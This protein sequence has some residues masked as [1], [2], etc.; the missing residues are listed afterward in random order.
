[1]KEMMFH[2]VLWMSTTKFAK[3]AAALYVMFDASGDEFV[4]GRLQCTVERFVSILL[5][6]AG[7]SGT[8]CSPGYH[9]SYCRKIKQI[10]S[11]FNETQQ[12][13]FIIIFTLTTCFGRLTIIR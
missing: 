13:I 8:H 11:G 5:M 2:L 7:C 12:Y 6:C 3:H 1:M 4:Y 10:A 9:I